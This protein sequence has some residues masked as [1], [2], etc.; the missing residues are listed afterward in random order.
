MKR[1]KKAYYDEY[2]E[3]NWNN[4]KNTGK[5]IKSLISLKTV[6][7]DVATVLSRHNGYTIISPYDQSL[8]FYS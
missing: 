6:A 3:T 8:C 1:S 5:G 7:S 2:F 4:V